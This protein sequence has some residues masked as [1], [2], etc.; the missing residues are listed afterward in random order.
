M[1]DPVTIGAIAAGVGKLASGFGIG[2]KKKSL[3]SQLYAQQEVQRYQDIHRPRDIVDGAKLAGLHP[4]A[5]LGLNPVGGSATVSS[6]DGFDPASIGQGV[7]RAL[8]VGKDKMQRELDALTLEKAKLENDYLRTQVAGSVQRLKST[9]Q[10]PA[11]NS[12]TPVTGVNS[13][14][15]EVLRDQEIAKDYLD[16]GRT[17]GNHASFKKYALGNG[18]SANLPYSQD[19]WAEGLGELP[20]WYKHPKM[21][22]VLYKRHYKKTPGYWIAKK[23]K[24]WRK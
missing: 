18:Q 20:F 13:Q 19:G 15:V 7:D 24:K 8:N 9:A 21:A 2:S 6:S 4:L 1:V 17:A 12:N 5:V 10:T 11:Y 16:T 23:W 3:K 14:R 22:E